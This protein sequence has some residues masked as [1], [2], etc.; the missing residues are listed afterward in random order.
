MKI[1]KK[2]RAGLLLTILIL[3]PCVALFAH[4]KSV[5]AEPFQDQSDWR[6]AKYTLSNKSTIIA[7]F[8]SG[9]PPVNFTDSVPGDSKHNYLANTN[10]S[11]VCKGS[12][13]LSGS[14]PFSDRPIDGSIDVGLQISGGAIPCPDGVK[15]NDSS[16]S[17]INNLSA[18][19]E[20]ADTGPKT[21]S[22]NGKTYQQID[23]G[24]NATVY[25]IST[26]VNKCYGNSLI[27]LAQEATK[28]A[29]LVSATEVA[30]QLSPSRTGDEIS[31]HVNLPSGF[32]VSGT[33]GKCVYGG[34]TQEVSVSS[35]GIVTAPSQ[36]KPPPADED[37]CAD[38]AFG[39]AWL[40]CPLLIAAQDFTNKL[41]DLFESL[42]SYTIPP[43][44]TGDGGMAQVKQSWAIFRTLASGLLVVVLLIVVIS[45]AIGGTFLDAYS[46]RKML[47]KIVIAVIAMQLSWVLVVWIV[48]LTDHLGKGIADLM[49]QPFHGA[50]QMSLG[51][52]LDHAH[53]GTGQQAA[54]NWVGIMGGL[55]LG[56]AALPS[57]LVL[58]V[59]AAVGLLVGFVA[60]IL[61]KLVIIITLI[62]VPVALILWILPG[63]GT[64]KLWKMWLDNFTK[65]LLMFPLVVMLV[66]GGR[67]LAY[68]A[69]TQGQG[70]FLNLLIVMVGFFGPLFIIPKAYKWGGSA[71]QLAG[72]AVASIGKPVN[73]KLGAGAKGIG[74]RWQGEKAKKYDPNAKW[75][76]R[77]L[78]RIQS[79]HIIP[80]VPGLKGAAE[81]SRRLTIA[82]GDKWATE[83]NEEAAALVGRTQEKALAGYDSH[84]VDADGNYLIRR[85]NA[86]GQYTNAAGTVVGRNDA[87]NILQVLG[88][89][90]ESRRLA[91]FEHMT[92]VEAGKQALID[93]AGNDGKSETAKRA[94]QAAVKQLIDT[95][96]EIELQKSRIVG[97]A[98]QGRRVNETSMWRDTITNSPPHY[99][100]INGSR[101][102]LAPDLEESAQSAATRRL[103]AT[104]IIP[105]GRVLQYESASAAERREI[106][107]EKARIAIERLTPEQVSQAHYGLYDDIGIVGNEAAIDPKTLAPV[108]DAAGNPMNISQLL[109]QRLI[110]FKHAPGPVGPSAIGSLHGGKQEHVDA[111][112]RAAGYTLNT[113]P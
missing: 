83:R 102:D 54:I 87:S 22:Y 64:Q 42:L 1:H 57:M 3:V 24:A 101:P 84:D 23:Q 40:A 72:G 78:R 61:R 10:D 65:A 17:V 81:R 110:D 15:F 63:N 107:V 100:A 20:P 7:T 6:N 46:V 75:Q 11:G 59:S 71:M 38:G 60:L 32:P 93:I 58:L 45:Q 12:I 52:L 97:G 62:F 89:D 50:S 33:L 92:G 68:I 85:K 39:L 18:G 70:T 69:G 25:G 8:P 98:N 28:D 73:E 36:P 16:I 35:S 31:N 48:E 67:I 51:A 113:L 37:S 77:G 94:A 53:I 82:K 105:P 90:K 49:Y 27:V 43:N 106:D 4:Q 14:S 80:P 103:R 13:N 111:A 112:L 19:G 30:V 21:L 56:T 109:A 79:G 104:G 29:S 41:T 34:S 9:H 66:A 47:P 44:P 26:D 5:S 99:G 55:V 86:A 2:V 91:S 74:E 76:S 96:S 108:L 88:N 95:H